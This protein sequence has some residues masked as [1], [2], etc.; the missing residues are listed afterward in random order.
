MGINVTIKGMNEA[1]RKLRS[2]NNGRINKEVKVRVLRAAGAQLETA[3][4]KN[5]TRTDYT[6]AQLTAMGHPYA[7]RQGSIKV[8]PDKP[9][10]IHRQSGSFSNSLNV[11]L[12]TTGEPKWS[13][14]FKYGAKRYFK[15]LITGTRVMLPRNVLYDTS[16]NEVIQ[17][18]MVKAAAGVFKRELKKQMGR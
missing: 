5:I 16:Q 4:R 14:G 3:T 8:H 1:I 13:I 17:R 9:Y 2:L 11:K 12:R 15:Y 18:N 10:V 7:R 6:Q